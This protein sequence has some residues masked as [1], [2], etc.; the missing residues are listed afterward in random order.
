MGLGAIGAIG[1]SNVKR[2]LAYS[3][4]ANIGFA[5]VGVAAGT[6]KGVEGVLFYMAVYLAMTLGSF[7]VVLQLRTDKGQPVEALNDFAGLSRTRPGL[8]AAL[9]IFMFSLA[10]IPPLLGFW[11]KFAVF[12]AAVDA[13]LY[14]LSVIGVVTSV[15]GAYYY[16]RLVKLM[17]FDDPAATLESDG[18]RINGGLIAAAAL[19]CSPIGMLAITPIVTAAGQAAR[20][21]FQAA[22]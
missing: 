18:S 16:L 11:P 13:G 10:G 9:A 15:V 1:Q 12:T 4:I 22:G 3:S 6:P 17:Y 20:A 21:L 7:L 2:L 5:L 14:S 19:F 8:A